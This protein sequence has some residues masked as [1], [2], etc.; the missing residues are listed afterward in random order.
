MPFGVGAQQHAPVKIYSLEECL[1]VGLERSYSVRIARGEERM[2]ANNATWG[3]A[4]FLPEVGLSAGYDAAIDDSRTTPRAG[5]AV[6]EAGALTQGLSAGLDVTWMMSN[7]FGVQTNWKRLR[8]LEAMGEL[9]ARIAIEDF[10]AALTAEYYNYIQQSIRLKNYNYAVGLSRERLRIVEARYLLGSGSRLDV[11]QAQ[12]DFNAD[13]SQ[14]IIQRERIATSRIRLNE[15]MACEDVDEQFGVRDS[16]IAIDHTLEW[17][18]LYDDMMATSAPLALARSDGRISE[19]DLRTVKSRAYPYLSLD[20]G[21][22]YNYNVYDRGGTRDRHRW[23]PTAGLTMGFTI[24]DGRRGRQIRNARIE[25]ENARLRVSEMETALRAD[26]ATF[27]QAYRNNLQL[28][29]LEGENVVSARQNYEIARDRYMLGDLSGIE[30]REAQ[31]SL[32]DADERILVAQYNTKICEIS[33]MQ[34]S[35]RVSSYV[36]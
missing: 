31:K 17:S 12:V 16:V 10:V 9:G 14:L 28:L 1:A 15:L 2:A 33:L 7:G 35:G 6:E 24:F 19:L 27:W 23:G 29:A 4:G 3:N 13:S 11:L 20:A 21:Y 26:L 5:A 32:L 30:M 18:E 25:V 22:G 8:E 34:I 36:E